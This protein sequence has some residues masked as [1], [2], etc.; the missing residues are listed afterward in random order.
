MFSLRRMGAFVRPYWLISTLLVLS[1]ILAV[2]MELVVPRALRY[3]IDF[4]ITPGDMGGIV[5][6]VLVMVGAALV[7]AL[8]TLGQGVFRARLSQG[9]AYDMRSALFAHIQTF[10]FA[11]LDNLQTGELITRISSD[12]ELVRMFMGNGLA[13]FLRAILMIGGSVV[14]MFFVDAQ[15]TLMMFIILP[16]AGLIIWVTMHLAQPLF[17][18]VQEKLSALN[19]IVQENLAGVR[20]VKAFVRESYEMNRFRDYS[21]DYMIQHIR[22]GRLMAVVLPLLTILTGLGTVVVVWYGGSSVISERLTIGQLVAFNSYLLIGMAPLLLLG[23]ILTMFSRADASASRVWEVLDMQPALPVAPSPHTAAKMQGHVQFHD[24]SFNYELSGT[25]VF[26]ESSSENRSVPP[27]PVSK[28]PEN[29]LSNNGL[30]LKNRTVL[31]NINFDTQPGQQFALLGATGSGKSTLVNLIPRFYDVTGGSITIDG[32]DVRDWDLETLRKQIGVVLQQTTLFSGT[33]R[34]NIAYG[35]SE[36]SLDEV[37]AAAQAAQAHEFIM[38]MP[39]GYDAIVEERGANLSGGQK[40]RI[41]IARAMLISPAILILDDSTSAVDGPT[42][43]RIQEAL[44]ELKRQS[45][46]FIVAQRLS[47]VL[48]A[49]TILILENGRLVD[50]GTHEELLRDSTIYQEIVASQ[51]SPSGSDQ[52]E[53][54]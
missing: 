6:G 39:G 26:S 22:V 30:P 21:D 5:R 33:I 4:G 7:G 38:A 12:V 11:N 14:M 44:K 3:V 17:T 35:R 37:I 36:A 20:V 41:A 51:M 31:H 42:E 50:Q 27:N 10:S 34:D 43:A 32:V 45:T 49:D 1:V 8:T 46:T 13:L 28:E 24:V 23:N 48:E 40:Q 52:E 54:L 53:A 29:A 16:L 19:A 25:R 18:V 9:L 15:L 47:S 2:A